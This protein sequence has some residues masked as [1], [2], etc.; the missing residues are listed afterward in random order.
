MVGSLLCMY[1]CV[2]KHPKCECVCVCLFVCNREKETHTHT[3]KPKLHIY[4]LSFF[5]FVRKYISTILE[6]AVYHMNMLA[7]AQALPP[8]RGCFEPVSV[9]NILKAG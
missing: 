1:M 5:H 8:C 7:E 4:L 2:Y 3:Q 9:T 6:P